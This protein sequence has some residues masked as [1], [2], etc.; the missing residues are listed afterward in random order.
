MWT[1]YITKQDDRWD[2][3]SYQ[4]YGVSDKFDIIQQA[5]EK[6][7]PPEILYSPL[8]PAG[9][10]LKIPILEEKPIKKLPKPVWKE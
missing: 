5:N 3:I 4:F 1:E 7:I 9:L 10:R 8:L 2:L 6:N